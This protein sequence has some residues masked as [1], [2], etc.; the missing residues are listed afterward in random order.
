MKLFSLLTLLWRCN[1]KLPLQIRSVPLEISSSPKKWEAFHFYSLP[2]LP[3][4][5][6]VFPT[7]TLKLGTAL[8]FRAGCASH[9]DVKFHISTLSRRND[10]TPEPKDGYLYCFVAS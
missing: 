7:R 4:S 10:S 6:K 9:R 3:L 5:L 1:F 2:L 8:Y